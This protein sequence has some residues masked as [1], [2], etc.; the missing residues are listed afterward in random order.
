MIGLIRQVIETVAQLINS[1]PTALLSI[2]DQT[3]GTI[4]GG[5]T[6]NEFVSYNKEISIENTPLEKIIPS[7]EAHTYPGK[8]IESLPFPTYKDANKK[9]NFSCLCLPLLSGEE[10]VKG[11]LIIA[12]NRG[13]LLPSEQLK[14]LNTILPL[15]AAILENNLEHEHLVQIAT[16]DELTNLYTRSYFDTRLQEEFT[17]VR[18]HGGVFSLLMID[19]DSFKRIN[20]I[21]GYKEGN[22]ALKQVAKIVDSSIRKEIDIPCRY[23]GTQFMLLLPNT[24]VD[25]AYIL[26]ERIRQR[27]ETNKVTTQ[28]GA[29]I[30]ITVSI[31]LTHNVEIAHED[32]V[33]DDSTEQ[34]PNSI[35]EVS[36]EE[37]I[38]RADLMLHAAKKAGRNQVMVWW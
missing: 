6:K 32:L 38:Q 2:K 7:K 12:Q 8:V 18:R 16:T 35:T 23:A 10:Q 20:D 11:I 31:G 19:V 15:I 9:S 25:G 29:T 36:K 34:D 13:S 1:K 14:T 28:K 24:D 4:I 26:A 22:K 5:W 33:D 27:C 30:R 37:V 21:Y 17:R 3:K